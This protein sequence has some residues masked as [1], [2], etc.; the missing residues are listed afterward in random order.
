MKQHAFGILI[1]S[2]VGLIGLGFLVFW[3]GL[4]TGA[5]AAI[6]SPGSLAGPGLGLL[7]GLSVLGA[8][9]LAYRAGLN[10][11]RLQLELKD[12]AL[13]EA[14]DR[15]RMLSD[16]SPDAI[17]L[18]DPYDEQV[19]WPIV[20]CSPVACEMNGYSREELI[21]QPIDI[22]HPAANTAAGKAVYLN[23]L[24]QQGR[25][26]Y[27]TVHKRK[28]GSLITVEVSTTLVNAGGRELVLGIDRDVSLRHGIEDEL[29]R[30]NQAMLV[31]NRVAIGVSSTLQLEDILQQL[32]EAAEQ[33][34]PSAIA[35]TV[36]IFDESGEF[37]E[38]MS[39]SAGMV[40]TRH[41]V[42]FRI[43]TG[44]AG[45]AVKEQRVINVSDVHT[46]PRFIRGE[47]LPKFHSLLV[48]PLVSATHVWGTLSVE[49]L[50][51]AAFDEDDEILASLLA[52]QA[53]VA[54]ENAHLYQSEQR[55]R[56]ISDTL[57]DI[58]MVFTG[59]LRHEDILRRLL[60]QVA[61]VVEY[62]AASV[63]LIEPDGSFRR[64]AW[65]GDGRYGN[66]SDELPSVWQA[67][68]P[69]MMKQ[70]VELN[71]TVVVGDTRDCEG[72]LQNPAFD[73][74]RSWVGAPIRARGQVVAIFCL[75]HHDPYFYTHSDRA[76]LDTLATQ[77]SLAVENALLFEQVQDN[78]DR[79]E[80]EVE[81][82]T[83]EIRVQTDRMDAILRNID[84]VVLILSLGGHINYANQAMQRL[85]GWKEADVLDSGMN[86]LLYSGVPRRRFRDLVHSL[87]QHT[88]W[89]GEIVLQHRDGY[90][91]PVEASILPYRDE[92]D[93][94]V[95]F[96]AS[97]RPMADAQVLER[98]KGQFMSLISHEL[99][100]P[101]TNLKLH[102]HL[103]RRMLG[104]SSPAER[105][106]SA[107]DQQTTRLVSLMEKILA[108][109]RLTDVD[110]LQL[111]QVIYFSS[112]LESL[113]TRFV[114]RAA[115]QGVVLEV[116]SPPA[117]LD[118]I[119]GDE[120]WLAQACYELIENAL[121][122]TPPG[123][124]VDIDL[125]EF[126][127]RHQPYAGLRVR[128]TGP[129]IDRQDLQSLNAAFSRGRP[130]QMGDTMGMGLGLF[131]AQTVGERHGGGL[132][133]ESQPGEGSAFTLYIPRQGRLNS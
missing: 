104:D 24:K 113:R 84:D 58:G 64:F 25:L 15:Y 36:Q 22:L 48:A 46:D 9:L 43:G 21:G 54:V 33:V 12:R 75:D 105:T 97:M 59:A 68:A 74:V 62:D 110:T 124:R 94:V 35:V 92:D 118:V 121:M 129:G 80:S 98:M 18:I 31:L 81:E 69:T 103:L 77:I 1:L 101:L 8:G 126:E 40:Q 119:Q 51:V 13:Q 116:I 67:S 61:R 125:V 41:R 44:I 32:V 107:L 109:T 26:N 91:V 99:R 127:L 11:M 86:S 2:L 93:Q 79:L 38:T 50:E 55:Q 72:W 70:A 82:R 133:V 34:F 20:E 115:Q 112:L 106:L 4:Q 45:L 123:G 73:W 83:A 78:A 102:L 89:R 108:V 49:S 87:R 130:Q 7:A 23:M 16:N 19:P 47:H 100:T 120:Q 128:D 122:Y 65:V 52:R 57:R 10:R 6:G 76:I 29:L 114:D 85:L 132:K 95:G 96:I 28:D 71:E 63:W 5:N 17:F 3:L 117:D 14:E 111:N 60:E 42:N 90:P 131:I 27:E 30:R 37:M 66:P 88:P 56:G 53:G 39:A